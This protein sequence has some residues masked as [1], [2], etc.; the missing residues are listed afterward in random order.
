M[1]VLRIVLP[2]RIFFVGL[3]FFFYLGLRAQEAPSWLT[4]PEANR[5][6][7]SVLTTLKLEE[8][9]AQ[10]FMLVG[11]ARGDKHEDKAILTLV[12]KQGVGGV[13]FLQGNR[14]RMRTLTH[15]LCPRG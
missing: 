3:F 6:A 5:W 15:K 12:E 7:D 4:S 8:R 13:M 9:I 1:S 14:E 10:S 2:R 11:Y